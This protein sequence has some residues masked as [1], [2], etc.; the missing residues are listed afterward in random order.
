MELA[1][2]DQRAPLLSLVLLVTP[3]LALADETAPRTSILKVY[4]VGNIVSGAAIR[5][6]SSSATTS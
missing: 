2:M 1:Q 6:H 5:A 3:V 4:R